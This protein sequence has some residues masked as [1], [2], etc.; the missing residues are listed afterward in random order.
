MPSQRRR[1]RQ[2]DRRQRELACRGPSHHGDD[3][4]RRLHRDALR[5]DGEREGEPRGV[6]H[7]PGGAR[8]RDQRSSPV[9]CSCPT[10]LASSCLAGPWNTVVKQLGTLGSA[11][12]V[13]CWAATLVEGKTL[14]LSWAKS[15]PALF[16][17]LGLVAFGGVEVEDR[18]AHAQ[19]GG[20]LVLTGETAAPASAAGRRP[21][22]ARSNRWGSPTARGGAFFACASTPWPPLADAGPAA[23]P[24][25]RPDA[26]S[27]AGNR[28]A[29]LATGGRPRRS[30]SR[31]LLLLS[32]AAPWISRLPRRIPGAWER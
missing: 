11:I 2:A 19:A 18:R 28:T 24:M 31:P 16:W 23:R 9:S 29:A 7:E 6:R 25:S 32:L 20:Q 27:S 8:R 5:R 21:S 26:R 14:T 30:P 13:Y 15:V 3:G 1:E 22:P 4:D 17:K 10:S 12:V